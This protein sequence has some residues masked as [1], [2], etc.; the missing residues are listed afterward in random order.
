[1]AI[2]ISKIDIY[3]FEAAIR[4]MRNSH[5]SWDKSDSEYLPMASDLKQKRFFLGPSDLGLASVLAA[6]GGSEA[7]FRRM[8]IVTMDILAPLYWWKEFDTYKVG[9][10]ANSTST[11][12]SI[13]KKKFELNDFSVEQMSSSVA[14]NHM[15]ITIHVL[16]ELRDLYLNEE[17]PFWKKMYW[18]D[19]IHLLPSGYNQLRT[20]FMNYEVLAHMV[21][22]RRNHKLDEWKVF[23][24]KMMKDLPYA[25]E[26]IFPEFWEQEQTN[27]TK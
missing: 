11:M 8:I 4:G 5:Q 25:D 16:N 2:E 27:G 9:T 21:S 20:V 13:M 7:K 12:H 6:A 24:R 19:V 26:L 22:D 10:V 18:N 3:G 15:L 23:C 17:R 14:G 1:M